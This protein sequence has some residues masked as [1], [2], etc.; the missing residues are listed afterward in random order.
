MTPT[1]ARA[2]AATAHALLCRTRCFARANRIRPT[3]RT[4]SGAPV[5]AVGPQGCAEK[6]GGVK[7]GDDELDVAIVGGGMVGL[8]VACAL[9]NMP[10][11]KHLRVAV[12]DSNPA[13]KSRNYL[14]KDGVPDSRVSTVTPATI[15]IFRDIGAWEHILQQRHAFFGKMQVWDYTGLGYTRYSARDV[16]KEYLGF[17]FSNELWMILICI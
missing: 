4:F 16:G 17:V 9:S 8:A 5:G 12:I 2:S 13:L 11:T 7:V 15:S 6:V 1:P 10:L 3:T 14:K